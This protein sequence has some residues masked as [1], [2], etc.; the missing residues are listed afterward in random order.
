MEASSLNPIETHPT[1]APSGPAEKSN[2]T[3]GRTTRW[4]VFGLLA[5]LVAISDQLL[6]A[7]IVAKYDPYTPTPVLGDWLRVDFIHNG[8]GLFGLLQGSAPVLAGV[9]VLVAAVLIGVELRSGWRSLLLTVALGLLLGGAVGNFID[10]LTLGY[11]VDFAD[12]GIGTWRWYI[13]NVADAAVTVAIL[14][15][16]VMWFVA[17]RQLGG[18]LSGKADGVAD[19]AAGADASVDADAGTAAETPSEGSDRSVAG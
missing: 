12:I 7:W 18:G 10:R 1:T 16:V 9:T 4:L 17:P 5:A 11:V 19:G 8:G 3:R 2:A 13:F 15:M 14:L 6:K